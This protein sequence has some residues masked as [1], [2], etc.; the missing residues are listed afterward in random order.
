MF[1][2]PH[3]DNMRMYKKGYSKLRISTSTFNTFQ[4]RILQK[5]QNFLL[6]K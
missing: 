1:D 6:N 5:T 3:N 2:I 4:S